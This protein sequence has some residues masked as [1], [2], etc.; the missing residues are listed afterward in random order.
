MNNAQ[1]RPGEFQGDVGDIRA[2]QAVGLCE[3]QEASG[4]V[5]PSMEIRRPRAGELPLDAIKFVET[6]DVV[7]HDYTIMR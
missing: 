7:G 2:A 4:G 1:H 5:V 3:Q 6:N